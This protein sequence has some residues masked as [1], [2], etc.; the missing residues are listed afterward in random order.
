VRALIPFILGIT[1]TAL[2][3]MQHNHSVKGLWR[4]SFVTSLGLGG[5]QF[6]MV[7]WAVKQGPEFWIFQAGAAI[8][9]A[10]GSFIATRG[11]SFRP[12]GRRGP[13]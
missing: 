6:F 13:P 2:A 11:S 9:S 4:R 3:C 8:G 12:F 10:L 1:T 7:Q 5:C